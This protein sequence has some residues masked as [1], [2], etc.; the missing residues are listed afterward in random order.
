LTD[1]GELLVGLVVIW[2]A[3]KLGGEGLERWGS[4][5]FSA[6]SWLAF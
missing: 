1:S 3:A 6:S 2:L 4:R 5:R